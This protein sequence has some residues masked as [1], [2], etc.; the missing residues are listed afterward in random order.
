MTLRKGQY[1]FNEIAKTHELADHKC[2]ASAELYP[3]YNLHQILFYMSDE[4]FDKMMN[5]F[6]EKKNG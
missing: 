2:P 6:E 5:K 4:E 1:L 3:Y